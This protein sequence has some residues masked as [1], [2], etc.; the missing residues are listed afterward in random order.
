MAQE[1]PINRTYRRTLAIALLLFFVTLTG[2]I[3]LLI[4]T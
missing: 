1:P 2:A 3:I 4:I